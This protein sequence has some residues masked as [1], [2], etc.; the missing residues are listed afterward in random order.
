MPAHDLKNEAEH[1]EALV[2]RH[3]LETVL[4]LLAEICREKAEHLRCH[5]QDHTT[6]RVWD[7]AASR[8]EAAVAKIEL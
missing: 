2:D 5:W 3:G 1:L 8:I 4:N 7:R 6:A